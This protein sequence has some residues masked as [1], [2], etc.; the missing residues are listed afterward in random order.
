MPSPAFDRRAIPGDARIGRWTAADGWSYRTLERPQPAA[1]KGRGSLLF[2]GGRGDF[3]EK[4]L[5]AH[6]HW[7]RA[8]WNGIC[9]AA[10]SKASRPWSR[11]LPG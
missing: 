3:I 7:H 5:E 11:T 9:R 1:A 6:D 4:Y 10:I 8:G 2:A